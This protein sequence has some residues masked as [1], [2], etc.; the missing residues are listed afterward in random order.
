IPPSFFLSVELKYCQESLLRHL[1]V[2]NLA[3]SLLAL[4]LFLKQFSLPG[5]VTAVAFCGHILA[6]C[7]DCF[8]GNYLGS[9]GCLYGNVKLLSRYQFAQLFAH[10]AAEIICMTPVDK[11]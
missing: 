2:A 10:P 8:A 11:G 9:D 1:H 3:H 6:D 5:D 7:L 4:L